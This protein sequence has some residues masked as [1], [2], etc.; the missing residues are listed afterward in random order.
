MANTIGPPPTGAGWDE[1]YP[2]INDVYGNACFEIRDLRKGVRIRL[3]KEHSTIGVSS[4]G[5]EH[6][7]GSAV[8]YAGDYS[9]AWPTKR[10]DGITSLSSAD[11]G[12]MAI[13]TGSIPNRFAI[14]VHGTGWVVIGDIIGKSLTVRGNSSS[15]S[16]PISIALE[17]DTAA[18]PANKFRFAITA[19]NTLK[20]QGRNSAGTGWDDILTWVRGTLSM[21]AGS[22]IAMGGN[23]ITGLAAATTSGD[24]MRYDETVR[25]S[26]DQTVAGVKTF[27]SFPVTPSSAPTTNYQVANKKYVDDQRMESSKDGFTPNTAITTAVESVTLP[28][29]RIIKSGRTSLTGSGTIHFGNSFSAGCVPVVTI[30]AE[31]SAN[32]ALFY[33]LNSTPTKDGFSIYVESASHMIKLHWIAIGY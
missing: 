5:G 28:N 30:T 3:E 10:P 20:L 25:L 21:T 2:D 12:R 31:T 11:T 7:Q 29:G 24:A 17:D 33:A 23:K 26:S 15:Y 9:S 6:K 27:S 19:A 4:A 32:D 1:N 14:Y 8:S 16:N 18:D 22:A 13:D